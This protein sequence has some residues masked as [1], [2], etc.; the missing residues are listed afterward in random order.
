MKIKTNYQKLSYGFTLIE[1]LVVIAIIAILAAMLLPALARAK[2]KATEATCL[3]NQKQLGVA[4]SMYASDNK[5]ATIT[6]TP[7]AGFKNAG[8]FWFLDNAAPGSWGTSQAVALADVQG[9]LKTNNM[10]YQYAANVGVYHCPGDVRFNLPIG[11]GDAVG[12]AFDSYAFTGNVGGGDV[13]GAPDP[14]NFTKI[15]QTRRSSDC[16][17]FAEQCD[18]RGYN[19]GTFAGAVLMGPPKTYTFIDLFATYHGSVNT[20]CFGDGHAEAR[21]WLDPLIL[22]DGQTAVK[23]GVTAYEYSNSSMQ[24]PSATSQDAAW[25]IQHWVSPLNP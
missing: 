19:E 18:S 25:L 14:V 21:K 5:D 7:P 20:F 6:N 8:G 24:M 9:D 15:S 17:I 16:L 11:S 22:K 4:F 13:G 12:W 23:P 1:L 10:I 2:L 3:S